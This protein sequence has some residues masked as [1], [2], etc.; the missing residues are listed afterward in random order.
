MRSEAKKVQDLFFD[1]MKIAFPDTDLREARNAVI[2]S[3]TGAAPTPSPK[4]SVSS[5]NK[6]HKLINEVEGEASPSTKPFPRASVSTDEDTR[7]HSH[8]SKSQK[9]S[10]LASSSGRAERSQPDDLALPTHPGELV[11]CKKRRNDREKPRPGPV[12]PPSVG[13]S[14]RGPVPGPGQSQPA[15]RDVK[16]SPQVVNQQGWLQQPA[17]QTNASGGNVAWA[18]PVKRTRTDTGKRRGNHS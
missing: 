1:I 11:I 12:S 10:R 8:M 7:P 4:L 3:G 14:T 16:I 13:R 15:Q 17:Q 6:R 5:Q 18:T 9:D 2:F